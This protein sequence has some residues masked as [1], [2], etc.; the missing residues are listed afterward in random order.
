M[1]Y[2]VAHASG[3]GNGVLINV[4][5]YTDIQDYSLIKGSKIATYEHYTKNTNYPTGF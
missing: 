5:P 4:H 1:G 3:T 2:I